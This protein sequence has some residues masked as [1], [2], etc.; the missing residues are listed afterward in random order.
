[1]LRLATH[2]HTIPS[3]FLFIAIAEHNR[4]ANVVV[5]DSRTS[6]EKPDQVGCYGRPC[7]IAPQTQ[8]VCRDSVLGTRL[9]RDK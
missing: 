1:M 4:D 9:K 8:M 7:R 5:L 6:Y 2:E 3:H